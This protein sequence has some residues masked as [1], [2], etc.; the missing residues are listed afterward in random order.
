MSRVRTP[1]SPPEEPAATPS[2]GI[3]R[4]ARGRRTAPAIEASVAKPW[5]AL[6]LLQLTNYAAL[7]RLLGVARSNDVAFDIADRIAALLPD[8]AVTVFGRWTIEVETCV[9]DAAELDA[10]ANTLTTAATEPF[11]LDGEHH[12]IEL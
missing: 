11:D 9:A 7:R 8:A 10:F 6:A 2:G 12:A 3:A 5:V 1:N 4:R